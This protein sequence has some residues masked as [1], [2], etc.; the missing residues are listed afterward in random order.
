MSKVASLTTEYYEM[1]EAVYSS[2]YYTEDPSE[3]CLFL[4]SIDLLSLQEQVLLQNLIHD[5]FMLSRDVSRS[6]PTFVDVLCLSMFHVQDKVAQAI[7]SQKPHCQDRSWVSRALSSLPHWNGGRNHLIFSLIPSSTPLPVG[8][9]LLAT[10]AISQVIGGCCV[11]F[12][13]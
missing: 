12:D 10:S 6:T 3:A 7:L 4:P 8:Q 5:L 13:F 2:P 1:L 11:H 9:A